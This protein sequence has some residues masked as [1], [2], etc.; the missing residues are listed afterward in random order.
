MAQTVFRTPV[1]N[2]V[3]FQPQAS[4][5]QRDIGKDHFRYVS[6]LWQYHLTNAHSSVTTLLNNTLKN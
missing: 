3:R 6:F 2:E 5:G 4:G 1:T